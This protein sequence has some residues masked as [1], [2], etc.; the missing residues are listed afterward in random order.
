PPASPPEI[1]SAFSQYVD[2]IDGPSPDLSPCVFVAMSGEA[3]V[4][5]LGR[6]ARVIVQEGSLVHERPA[7]RLRPD[8]RVILGLGTNPW[9]PSDEFTEAVVAA[10]RESHPELVQKA[11]EW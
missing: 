1:Q 2:P 6:D 9:S 7:A 4:K 10:V 5:V 3:D 8:D 11:R